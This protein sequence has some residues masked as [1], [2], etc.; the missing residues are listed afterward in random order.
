MIDFIIFGIV[1]NAIMILGAMTGLS[2]EKY[3]PKAFQKGIGTVIGAGIGNA[4][5]DFMGGAT[6]ASWELAFG[7]AFGCIIGLVF[8]PLFKKIQDMYIERK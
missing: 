5:S 8:I 1:D 6:T 2:I 3:L 7:T 4:V